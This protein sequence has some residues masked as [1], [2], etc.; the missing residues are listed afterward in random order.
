LIT[1]NKNHHLGD[2]N[3]PT[4]KFS[5]PLDFNFYKIDDLVARKLDRLAPF[6]RFEIEK[7]KISKVDPIAELQK[8]NDLMMK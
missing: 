4:N 7:D 1:P 3:M 5:E 8:Q 6:D 2:K